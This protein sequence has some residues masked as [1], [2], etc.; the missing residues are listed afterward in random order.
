MGTPV[1][2]TVAE[3]PDS[4]IRLEVEV[5]EGAVQHAFEHAAAD[6]AETMKVPGFRKGKKIPL[7][8]VAARAGR[9]AL[10]TEAVRSHIDSWF[11]DAAMSSGIRPLSSPEVEW[12]ELPAQGGTF[13][14]TATV[15]VPPKPEVADWTIL[16]VPAPEVEVPSDVVDAEL[17]RVRASV[18]ELVPVSDRP[19]A[20]GDTVV[21]DLVAREEGKEPSEH[22]DYV[23]ELGTGRLADELEEVIPGM[24]QG[25]T[26]DVTIEL[27]E[28]R[29]GTVAVVLKEIKE[30]ALP[31]LDDEL[32]RS[33]TEFDTLAELRED[34]EWRLREQLD[35]E[36]DVR[37]RE[38]ALD[39]LVAASTVAGIEPLVEA[40]EAIAGRYPEP[41]RD[42]Y[43]ACDAAAM[44]A[45]WS[46]AMSEGA[47]SG[48][49]SDWRV[50][51]LICVAAD[52]VDFYEQARGAAAE[53]LGAEFVSIEGTNHL[54]MDTAPVDPAWPAI[55]RTL[56]GQV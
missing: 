55:L 23:V 53:I 52:D 43:L 27:P 46:A 15:P 24:A 16:E 21:V 26:K 37:F 10:A 44:R 11:W 41:V 28:G 47:V 35:R 39:A 50:R 18:A 48:N 4:K 25:E 3:L 1:K 42:A 49:L 12:D 22:R 5:P 9:E 7:P 29:S 32:A 2:T 51:C 33:A 31:A 54:G 13:R 45:A 17:E 14:F 30:K 38:D 6:L 34:I 40:F 19:A 36:L 8:V 20:P 56:R